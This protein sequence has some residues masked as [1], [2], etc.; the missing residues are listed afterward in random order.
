VAAFFSHFFPH[1]TDEDLAKALIQAQVF[2]LHTV[3]KSEIVE[4]PVFAQA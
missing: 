3:V 1:V 4:A 2:L